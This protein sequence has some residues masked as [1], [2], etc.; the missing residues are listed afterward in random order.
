MNTLH[1]TLLT[2]VSCAFFFHAN[3]QDSA[4]H[5]PR[6]G[7]QIGVSA[8][9]WAGNSDLTE[10]RIDQTPREGSLTTFNDGP[11]NGRPDGFRVPVSLG[12]LFRLSA[13]ST[14][15]IDAAYQEY[16]FREDRYAYID[17]PKVRV[18]GSLVRA[19]YFRPLTP[20]KRIGRCQLVG[21]WGGA[22]LF[23]ARNV[24]MDPVRH[25][26][27]DEVLSLNARARSAHL[28]AF[29]RLGLAHGRSQLTMSAFANLASSI[30][31]DWVR[32]L[33]GERASWF[34]NE[35]SYRYTGP[36]A[37]TLINDITFAYTYFFR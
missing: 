12:V 1:R 27:Y 18:V 32:H 14:V 33:D 17:L 9:T 6:L 19:S 8:L 29:L 35:G 5:E 13:H 15:G 25:P 37:P 11:A 23:L 24:S 26:Y 2:L 31:V 4:R 36:F 16:S 21:S 30:S 28:Q 7:V 22:A 10:G 20:R 34:K 3:G